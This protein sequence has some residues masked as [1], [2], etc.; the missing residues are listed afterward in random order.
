MSQND[1]YRWSPGDETEYDT[2]E[3]STASLECEGGKH[4]MRQGQVQ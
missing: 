2:W 4:E 3:L 1:A